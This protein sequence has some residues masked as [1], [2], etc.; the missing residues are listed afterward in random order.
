MPIQTRM[1]LFGVLFILELVLISLHEKNLAHQTLMH[2]FDRVKVTKVYACILYN[3]KNQ[4]HSQIV[5]AMNSV[6]LKINSESM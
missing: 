4:Q 1:G 6:V 2:D 5:V 3:P